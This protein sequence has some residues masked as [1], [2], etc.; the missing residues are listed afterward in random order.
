MTRPAG[1]ATAILWRRLDRPGHESALV[2]LRDQRWYLEGSAVFAHDA[3]ACRLDYSVICDDAWRTVSASVRGWV[4]TDDVQFD[5]AVNAG[6]HWTLNGRDCPDTAGCVDVDLNWSPS[7]NLL[8]IRRLRLA[9]GQEAA[10]RAAWL[11]F[12]SFALEPLEQRYRRLD[13][14]R[15]RYESGGGSFVA[16]LEVN[17]AG[18]VVHYPGFARADAGG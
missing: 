16:E 9:P 15:Y 5:L 8:P 7:T 3:T 11:R 2:C 13:E 17:D 14:S 10:V 4:G 6:G 18:F 1:A 12:P